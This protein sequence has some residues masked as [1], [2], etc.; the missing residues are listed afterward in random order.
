[1]GDV[2]YTLG[3]DIPPACEVHTGCTYNVFIMCLSC[4]DLSLCSVA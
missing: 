1:M 3:F 2:Y 4:I